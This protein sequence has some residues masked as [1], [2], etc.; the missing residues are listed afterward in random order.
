MV[1]GDQCYRQ[2]LRKSSVCTVQELRESSV[3]RSYMF[4]TPCFI[5][6]LWSFR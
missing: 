1:S 2:E 6:L 3:F 4:V 5:A